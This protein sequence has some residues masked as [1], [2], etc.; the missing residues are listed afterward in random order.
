M[1]LQQAAL[2]VPS[3]TKEH[4]STS[5]PYKNFKLSVA[6]STAPM[7]MPAAADPTAFDFSQELQTDDAH[8]SPQKHQLLAKNAK[9]SAPAPTANVPALTPAHAQR[10]KQRPGRT[11]IP[12]SR[13]RPLTE[14]SNSRRSSG[15]HPPPPSPA[16]Q[17]ATRTTLRLLT[18]KQSNA[19]R[20]AGELYI[21]VS[22]SAFEKLPC[23]ATATTAST[24]KAVPQ[25][26]AN[27][28]SRST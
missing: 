2:P 3:M 7:P 28:R 27:S 14:N 6:V 18:K 5:A 22:I 19:H 13:F 26:V 24:R 11:D 17:A 21:G 20:F 16:E 4:L 23:D 25:G 8:L 1:S 12:G 15:T 9:P 10:M